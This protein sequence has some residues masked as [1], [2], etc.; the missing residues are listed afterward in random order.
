MGK[1]GGFSPLRG[2]SKAWL[3]LGVLGAAPRLCP[4]PSTQ[5]AAPLASPF[6]R[7]ERRVEKELRPVPTVP[8]LGAAVSRAPS[9][10]PWS[11][12]WT[13]TAHGA[14]ALTPFAL[15]PRRLPG[16]TSTPWS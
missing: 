12:R 11:A 16:V 6:H 4:A 7:H 5:G 1:G 10:G 3:G 8:P 15:L 14:A 9:R 2:R 13:L